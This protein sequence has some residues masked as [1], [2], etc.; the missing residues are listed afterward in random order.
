MTTWKMTLAALL[1]AAAPAL[2]GPPMICMEFQCD[3]VAI[4]LGDNSLQPKKGFNTRKLPERTADALDKADS[5]IERM[6]TIR[7]AAIYAA[8]A[9]G[10]TE[11]VF[12]A[13]AWR[14]LNAE[15]SGDTRAYADALFDAGYFAATMANFGEKIDGSPAA[16]QG[17]AGYAWITRAIEL[18]DDDASM[19]FAASLATHPVM[20]S[21]KRDLFEHHVAMASLGIET[22][23]VLARNL[24][25]HM[26]HF[27]ESTERIVSKVNRER[28]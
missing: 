16:S 7:R 12:N 5:V 9:N 1:V 4:P 8:R 11:D 6:E 21:S 10:S 28:D 19:H 2:A 24:Q 14:A 22:D 25:A 17:L 15:V 23:P 18:S 27:D 20:R 3:E 26:N 13:L